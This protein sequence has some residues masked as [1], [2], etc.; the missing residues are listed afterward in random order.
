MDSTENKE[1]KPSVFSNLKKIKHIEFYVAG[2]AI[3]LM[4]LVYFSATIFKSSSTN[5][6]GN[7]PPEMSYADYQRRVEANLTKVVS[8]MKG[9][10]DTHVAI[11][12]ESSVELVIA[13]ITVNNGGS[14][15]STPQL[16]TENGVTK[17]LVIKEV[18]PT[19]IGVALTVEGAD[20]TRVRLNI[21]DTV[22]VLLH[23]P[24][25]KIV[26]QAA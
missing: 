11:A 17:P 22:S 7:S 19:I 8:T 20:D 9:V 3:A 5:S 23:I 26:I 18:Y 2:I 6:S 12:W 1:K 25:E 14:L 15:S 16:V 4:L 24:Y 13:Y 21:L 10:G